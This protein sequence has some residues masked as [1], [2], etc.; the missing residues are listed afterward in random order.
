M[1][2]K[3]VF[4]DIDGTLV[5][6]GEHSIPENTRMALRQLR[7]NGIRVFGLITLAMRYSTGM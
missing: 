3:A 5:P 4:F 1:M 7:D 6:F 2:I